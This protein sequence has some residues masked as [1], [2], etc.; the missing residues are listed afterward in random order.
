MDDCPTTLEPIELEESSNETND[1][2]TNS[3]R[4]DSKKK[5]SNASSLSR[6]TLT[7]NANE[8]SLQMCGQI[9]NFWMSS[10]HK[11]ISL[12]SPPLLLHCCYLYVSIVARL[13]EGSSS[14][15]RGRNKRFWTTEEDKALI[16]SLY[17][18]STDPH[19][20]C[21]NG[22]RSGYMNRLEELIGKAIPGCG[23]NSSPHI[24]SRLKTLL[25]KFRAITQML[26]TSGF[27]WDSERNMTSVDRSV[28][29]EYCKSDPNCKI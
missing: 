12:V 29:D 16:Y 24:D 4:M 1:E 8:S 23:L 10:M 22:F 28:Y 2:V 11:L 6:Q 9:L 19:W 15:G 17:E 18:L 14:G 27:K 13:N 7:S 21:E 25:D 5:N 26:A 20:K 3:H